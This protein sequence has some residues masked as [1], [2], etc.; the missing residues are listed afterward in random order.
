MILSASMEIS[1]QRLEFLKEHARKLSLQT[2][3]EK[4]ELMANIRETIQNIKTSYGE[5]YETDK[6]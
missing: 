5:F 6:F 1:I 2:S 3:V 4:T